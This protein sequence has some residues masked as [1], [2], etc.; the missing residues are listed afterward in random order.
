MDESKVKYYQRFV[1]KFKWTSVNSS[2]TSSTPVEQS[3]QESQHGNMSMED[4]KL[5]ETLQTRAKKRSNRYY[6]NDFEYFRMIRSEF[7][8]TK[9]ASQ[10]GYVN[11]IV[12]LVS[13]VL[14]PK[15]VLFIVM[16]S[17][18]YAHK[19]KLL[20]ETWLQWSQGNFFIFADTSNASIPLITLPQLKNKPSREDAQHRQLLGSQWII[21]NKSE[22][23]KNIKWV[24]FA[25]DDTWINIPALLSYL[26]F[27]DHRLLLSIGYIWDDMWVTGWSYFSGGGGIV[28]SQVAFMSTMPA[29]Y[30]K[31][32]PFQTWNDVTLMHCQKQ[33]GV[34]KIHSDR[35]FYDKAHA[36]GGFHHLIP[37]SY[38]GK[39]TFHYINDATTARRM[40]CDVAVYW[41]WPIKGCDDI[42]RDDMP[43]L[44]LP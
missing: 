33:K 28:F 2:N 5:N 20:T 41:K 26:Q 39:A 25:D 19:A 13:T 3:H 22:L 29:I 9:S 32:C 18:K 43:H 42:K 17:V 11:G 36:I 6:L 44:R 24:V 1:V 15:D 40:T 34:T 35:F 14:N 23:I 30:T 10:L 37:V 12:P 4:L 21:T 16:G 38:V 31:E 8:H 27:F 7:P